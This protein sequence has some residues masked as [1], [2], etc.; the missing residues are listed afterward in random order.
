[1][2]IIVCDSNKMMDLSSAE[3]LIKCNAHPNLVMKLSGENLLMLVADEGD[4]SYTIEGGGGLRWWSDVANGWWPEMT[5]ECLENGP[6]IGQ[7]LR[8]QN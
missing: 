7:K 4:T 5:V 2:I 3:A 1:M 8:C 6:A